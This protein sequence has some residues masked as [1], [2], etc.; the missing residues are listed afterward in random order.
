MATRARSQVLFQEHQSWF[1]FQ[2]KNDAKLNPQRDELEEPIRNKTAAQQ[3]MEAKA[4]PKTSVKE[5]SGV[6][7]RG[8]TFYKAGEEEDGAT[9]GKEKSTNSRSK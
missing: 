9:S 5:K 8:V 1:W 6:V 4:E 2:K 3:P 7:I